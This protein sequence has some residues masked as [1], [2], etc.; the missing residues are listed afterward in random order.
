MYIW[1]IVYDNTMLLIGK[2]WATFLKQ[3]WQFIIKF[4]YVKSL[5]LAPLSNFDVDILF[6]A[7]CLFL[8]SLVLSSPKSQKSKFLFLS[9]HFYFSKHLPTNVS[10]V[11]EP[12]YEKRSQICF[13]EDEFLSQRNE[14]ILTCSVTSVI[15]KIAKCL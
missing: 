8:F 10:T 4:Y 6:P 5:N 2:I 9:W 13:W 14:R 11:N 12:K 1:N 15:R 7:K 3:I